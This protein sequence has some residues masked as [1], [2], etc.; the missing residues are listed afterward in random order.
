MRCHRRGS[1]EGVRR[2]ALVI[3]TL[4]N[5]IHLSQLALLLANAG[6]SKSVCCVTDWRGQVLFR[7]FFTL[8][9]VLVLGFFPPFV[10][11]KDSSGLCPVCTVCYRHHPAGTL[12]LLGVQLQSLLHSPSFRFGL[13]KAGGTKEGP[14]LFWKGQSQPKWESCMDRFPVT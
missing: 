2:S 7:F 3:S 5:S 9:F 4:N 14:V 13:T 11:I 1:R 6:E 8:T 12:V 10:L